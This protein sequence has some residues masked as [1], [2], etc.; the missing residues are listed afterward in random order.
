MRG[1]LVVGILALLAAV[2]H[3][4]ES[5]Q[6]A[7]LE[8]EAGVAAQA[9]ACR[10]LREFGTAAAVPALAPLLER[11]ELAHDARMALEAIPGS[12]ASE[13]LQQAL[14]RTEGLLRAGLLDSLGERREAAAVAA[15]ADCL[16]DQDLPVV[17]S[18]A[19]ALGKIGTE[20]AA[21]QLEQAYGEAVGERRVAI[22][23]GWLGAACQ[24]FQQGRQEQ[25]AAIYEHLARPEE[26]R[27]L[28]QAALAGVVATAGDQRLARI[29]E[30]L[31]SDDPLL[32]HAAAQH[33]PALELA[34]LQ[35]VTRDGAELPEAAQ[36][37]VLTAI[38]LRGEPALAPLA[39][40]AVG[41]ESPAIARAAI[42]AVAQLAGAAGLDVL[43]PLAKHSEPL[44]DDAWQALA[45]LRGPEVDSGLITA[46]QTETQTEHQVRLIR[47]LDARD[48]A[49][50]VPALIRLATDSDGQVQVAAIG[51]LSRMAREEHVPAAVELLLTLPRGGLRDAVEKGVM[52]ALEPIPQADQRTAA[53]LA[54][55][56][57]DADAQQIEFLP[58]LG[59][60]GGDRALELVQTA[61]EHPRA[62]MYEA[63]VRAL[64]NWPNARVVTQLE[65]LAREARENHQ[66][67]WA[68]RALI[69][70]STLPGELADPQKLELLARA[71]PLATRDE[72]RVLAI[73]R[74]AAVRTV[75]ALQFV[76]P[77]LEDDRLAEPASQTVVELAH[78]TELRE[79][80]ADAFQSALRRVLQRTDDTDLANRARRYLDALDDSE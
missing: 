6:I 21:R 22:G 3:G 33:L 36:R 50:S 48:A 13:A 67:I 30:F 31:G 52:L 41:S 25:A 49:A 23:D 11:A 58:L 70:V 24:L 37:V 56:D 72:E 77:Y 38:R 64:A 15:V 63:G 14:A 61:L 2:G 34:E 47:T 7:I 26:S 66:R 78:H 18:A 19:L 43:L 4:G 74:A 5:E 80:H 8:S 29:R 60:I 51:A 69:R 35:A 17:T 59:R 65:R 40:Q 44:A 46:L 53:V 76:R 45:A 10:E 57:L 20:Q 32:R 75:E 28:R 39:I 16:A 79:A 62:E 55:V 12:E 42:A 73:Q 9:A 27:L 71:M 1:K 68:L 54:G